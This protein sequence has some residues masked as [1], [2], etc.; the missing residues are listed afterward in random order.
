MSRRDMIENVRGLTS[1]GRQ[2]IGEALV[3]VVTAWAEG[4]LSDERVLAIVRPLAVAANNL[5]AVDLEIAAKREP[6][7]REVAS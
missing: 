6:E 2:A 5:E 3:N 1:G 4:N 7:Q